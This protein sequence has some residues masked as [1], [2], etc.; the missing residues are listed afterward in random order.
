[1]I[2][3]DSRLLRTKIWCNSVCEPSTSS[4]PSNWVFSTSMVQRLGERNGGSE[5]E[6]ALLP[7]CL[8]RYV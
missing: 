3:P 7:S 4:E 1:M 2:V 8:H 5:P 6:K